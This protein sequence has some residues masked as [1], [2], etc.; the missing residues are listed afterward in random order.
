MLELGA[1]AFGKNAVTERMAP[2]TS[3][4]VEIEAFN[5]EVLRRIPMNFH[6][7][8]LR[9]RYRAAGLEELDMHGPLPIITALG[10]VAPRRIAR[11]VDADVRVEKIFQLSRDRDDRHRVAGT[12]CG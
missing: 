3:A 2:L 1:R 10:I 6:V 5:G 11:H 8:V 9:K 12:A 4:A 7:R